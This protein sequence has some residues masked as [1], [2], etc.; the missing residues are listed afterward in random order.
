MAIVIDPTA[1]LSE[2]I[3]WLFIVGAGVIIAVLTFFMMM[4]LWRYLKYKIKVTII[5]HVGDSHIVKSD[6]AQEVKEKTGKNYLKLLK[7]RVSIPVPNPDKYV[8]MGNKKQLFLHKHNDLFT[9]MLVTHN[10]PAAFEFKMDD[11]VSV[12]F[13]REQDHQEALETYRNAPSFWDRFQQPILF[14]SF[15]LIQFVLFFILFQKLGD[16]SIT[17]DA[18]QV[19]K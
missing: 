5:D 7:T 12:L 17:V 6:T 19:I 13:W 16:L 14:M 10:S 15:M 18:V 9:P 3:K 8:S 4:F 2:T 1:I 11:L